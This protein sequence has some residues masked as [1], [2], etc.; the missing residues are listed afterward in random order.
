MVDDLWELID[1]AGMWL[2]RG[3]GFPAM[4]GRVL[5]WLL[6][7]DPPDQT[8][9]ELMNALG[10]SKGSI[11]GATNTLV[12]ARLIDRFSERG[13]RADR[14]R[15]RP[16]AWDS[17]LLDQS[18]AKMARQLIAQGLEALADAPPQRR[19]R[20]EELDAFYAWWAERMPQLWEEWDEYRRN[21]LSGSRK[22]RPSPGRK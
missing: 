5:G 19:A 11:S 1:A 6:V 7:C 8:A 22:K 15:I 17:Q 13:E 12:R 16:G 18:D 10:A 9:A 20:L 21:R 14:F 4:T 3:Y 2:A